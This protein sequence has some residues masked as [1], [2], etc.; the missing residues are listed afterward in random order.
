MDLNIILL[1]LY[2][3]YFLLHF[4][5]L[6]FLSVESKAS[7]TYSRKVSRPMIAV[8]VSNSVRCSK[9]DQSSAIL[10]CCNLVLNFRKTFCCFSLLILF[11]HSF[12]HPISMV[13]MKNSRWF[14]PLTNTN[15]QF[16]I[17]LSLKKWQSYMN[18][19]LTASISHSIILH[20]TSVSIQILSNR[21]E[22][23]WFCVSLPSEF[24]DICQ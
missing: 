10:S 22:S 20:F 5:S 24:L 13:I 16:K 14:W 15:K 1:M 2:L 12:T 18:M 4:I 3:L 21:C 8:A 23:Q 9:R 11:I 19:T 7:L 6:C 17:T